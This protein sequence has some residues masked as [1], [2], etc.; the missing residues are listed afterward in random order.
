VTFDEDLPFGDD[1][2]PSSSAPT[3]AHAPVEVRTCDPDG[4]HHFSHLK[5]MALSGKQY[6]YAVNTQKPPSSAMLIGTAVHAMVL[7]G[8]PGKRVLRFGGDARKGAA[9]KAYQAAN[10]GAEILT[11]PEW[12][13]AAKCARAV[14]ADP[15][16]RAR[17]D[18]ARFE[19]PLAWEEDGI[20]FSTSGVDIVG[21]GA[22]GDLKT[23]TT[24]E[25]EAL[26]RQAFKMF[27]HCQLAF[28]RR[29]A[30]ANG[31]DVSRGLFLL[32]VETKGPHEVVD[33]ELSEGLIDLADRTVSLW[34]E[35]LRIYRDANQWPGYAQSPIP[36]DVP[37]W[38][39]EDDGEE[40]EL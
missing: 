18:G 35:K 3:T 26:Q 39:R 27:Y 38:M 6:I 10:P 12:D 28:Y 37:G 17:L 33:L 16:A 2:A 19:V 36:W 24:C 34:I 29:G 32:C 23:S 25:P 8:R 22:L 20:R 7:G 13:Q 15:L 9:W 31:L 4:T 5:R 1:D 14:L 30:R 40:G 11:A 21:G